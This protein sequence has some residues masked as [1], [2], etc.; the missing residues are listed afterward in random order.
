M[1]GLASLVNTMRESRFSEERRKGQL[2][3]YYENA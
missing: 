1:N 3:E 2:I